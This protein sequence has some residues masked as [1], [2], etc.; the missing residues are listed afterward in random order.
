M[1]KRIKSIVI[2][3]SCLIISSEIHSQ[4]F[5]FNVNDINKPSGE[6]VQDA[7]QYLDNYYEGNF[8]SKGIKKT[9]MSG[10]GYK[11]YQ[12]LK[13]F[14]ELRANEEG[15]IPYL[16]RWNSFME[17]PDILTLNMN[18]RCQSINKKQQQQKIQRKCEDI[19]ES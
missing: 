19:N 3:V 15:V 11:P 5:P 16:K 4:P 9:E 8:F 6:L 14:Y 1:N 17:Q 13:W 7:I 12:R 2:L 10:T 18:N